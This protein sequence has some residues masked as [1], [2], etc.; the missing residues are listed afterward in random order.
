MIPL[1]AS[2]CACK[3]IL[4]STEQWK[5]FVKTWFFNLCVRLCHGKY[6]KVH[7]KL[8]FSIYTALCYTILQKSFSK[9]GE[10]INGLTPMMIMVVMPQDGWPWTRITLPLVDS[11]L[12]GRSGMS[13]RDKMLTS[14]DITQRTVSWTLLL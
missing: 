13:H 4:W 12:K 7:E 9:G 8:L 1:G 2:S 6:L 11:F 10:R 5:I 14:Q 3:T